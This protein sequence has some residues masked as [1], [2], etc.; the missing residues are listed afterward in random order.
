MLSLHRWCAGLSVVVAALLVGDVRAEVRLPKIFGSNMVLQRGQDVP[1][2]G[3]AD[4]GEQVIVSIG[5]ASATATA[6]DDGAWKVALPSMDAGGPHVVTVK[7]SNT[8]TLENV[9][10]GEVW[11]CSG[12]SNMQ[13]AVDQSDDADLEKLTAKFSGIRLI[14]V[15]QVGT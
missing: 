8:L 15:P 2:W 6:A 9:L 3:W 13:W 12:Q 4:A 1:V 10:V 14:T 11:V 5:D 7:G